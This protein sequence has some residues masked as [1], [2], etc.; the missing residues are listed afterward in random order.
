MVLL[1]L[2]VGATL[3]ETT[4]L[5]PVETGGL[6]YEVDR[7]ADVEAGSGFTGVGRVPLPLPEE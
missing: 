5:V 7:V 2:F 4:L 6:R 1:P 3:E